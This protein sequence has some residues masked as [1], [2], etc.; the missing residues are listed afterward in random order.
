MVLSM[1]FA[2]LLITRLMTYKSRQYKPIDTEYGF[3][4]L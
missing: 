1:V 3:V 2:S 4:E